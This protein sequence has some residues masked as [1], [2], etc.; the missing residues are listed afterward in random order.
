MNSPLRRNISTQTTHEQVQV[1]KDNAREAFELGDLPKAVES[2]S[3]AIAAIRRHLKQQRQNSE[4]PNEQP[5]HKSLEDSSD[6]RHAEYHFVDPDGEFSSELGILHG[7]RA[8]INL[9][10][11]NF[12]WA[13]KDASV[14]AE[15]GMWKGHY[16]A[17]VALRHLGR[18]QDA[19]D[20][21]KAILKDHAEIISESQRKEIEELEDIL[22]KETEMRQS[23]SE[24]NEADVMMK[25][26]K[27]VQSMDQGVDVSEKL[28]GQF[29]YFFAKR[30]QRGYI[31]RI[32]NFLKDKNIAAD[33]R[34]YT[35]ILQS[36]VYSHNAEKEKSLL[37]IKE[38]LE[39]MG[40]QSVPL[41]DVGYLALLRYVVRYCNSDDE[42]LN[43]LF[44]TA[45]IL[46]SMEETNHNVLSY[47]EVLAFLD[48]ERTIT[49]PIMKTVFSKMN[50]PPDVRLFTRLVQQVK[51]I[52]TAVDI[53]N[54]MLRDHGVDYTVQFY[55][56]LLSRMSKAKDKRTLGIYKAMRHHNLLP[57]AVTY[58]ILLLDAKRWRNS[59]HYDGIIA[60]M[61]KRKISL[62]DV[63][64]TFHRS[65]PESER[66]QRSNRRQLTKPVQSYNVEHNDEVTSIQKRISGYEN[67]QRTRREPEQKRKSRGEYGH[68]F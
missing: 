26:E 58:R 13:L 17:A 66:V 34:V 6:Q 37:D 57:D 32:F 60:E 46:S 47:V 14:S 56:A 2:Y 52:D 54:F 48:C 49:S 63:R 8:L 16:R 68:R 55:N 67:T 39:E 62:N 3:A 27:A 36:F 18:Y 29:V 51:E 35:S 33:V 22:E 15:Y 42:K 44:T 40:R 5:D 61:D 24:G 43:P 45:G 11:E 31:R 21:L 64:M 19:L 30:R 10:Q 41:N 7:N 1:L 28:I 12:H 59:D 9:R 4:H 53:H 20:H 38:L 50:T 25:F 23:I 65:G